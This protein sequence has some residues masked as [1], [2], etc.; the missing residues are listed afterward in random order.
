MPDQLSTLNSQQQLTVQGFPIR[1]GPGGAY[2]PK[3]IQGMQTMIIW[4]NRHADAPDYW[5]RVLICHAFER[6]FPR[7][8]QDAPAADAIEIVAEDWVDIVGEGM[9]EE[10]DRERIIAGFKLIFRECKRWPQPAELL[11]RLPRRQVKVKVEEDFSQSQ[12]Q[13][14]S[15]LEA[16]HARGSAAL[17]EILEGLK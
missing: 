9:N 12:P 13:S 10:Q 17:N 7:R 6:M 5:L 4:R 8:M 2:L 3:T 16:A 11:K 14:Q 1:T 15:D